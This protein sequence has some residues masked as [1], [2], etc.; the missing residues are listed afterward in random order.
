MSGKTHRRMAVSVGFYLLIAAFLFF[1]LRGTDWQGILAL[2]VNPLYLL[3]AIPFSLAPRFLQPLA[4]GALI[5]GYGDR[6]PAYP[7]LTLVYAKSWLARYIPG[8]LVWIGGK[9]LFGR[10][11][12]V[13][14]RVLA[15]TSVA[16]A[17]IQIVTA[18]VFS[19]LIFTVTGQLGRLG[20]GIRLFS[21]A[22]L[23]VLSAGLVPPVF[24]T[25]VA[26]VHRL[27]SKEPAGG[28]LS[29]APFLKVVGFYIGIHA[30][31]AI[32]LYL[33]LKAVYPQLSLASLPYLTASFLLGGAL[34]T[35]AV[36]AP[37]GIGVREGVL[38][39]LLGQI[40]PK[41]VT[42]VAVLFL[43]LWGIAMDLLY[44]VLAIALNGYR[45]V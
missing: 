24:N 29:F 17:G 36:L 26:R 8:K 18:L 5:A 13:G 39:V 7:Q 30:L 14:G 37:S 44:Y 38:I 21:L 25:L 12:G 43:R 19:F 23:C 2:R 10:Q 32:P 33:L 20:S 22:A 9:V 4:W 1:A 45:R 40:V 31:S 11:F 15:L 28:S 35:L 42:V 41:E 34:G 27:A 16:E 6:P 3:V